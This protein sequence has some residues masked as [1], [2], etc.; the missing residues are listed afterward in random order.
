MEALRECIPDPRQRRK[1]NWSEPNLRSF[2]RE[3]ILPPLSPSIL[4]PQVTLQRLCYTELYSLSPA[5][6]GEPFLWAHPHRRRE[7]GG[8]DL[9]CGSSV[10]QSIPLPLSTLGKAW[11]AEPQGPADLGYGFRSSGQATVWGSST[12]RGLDPVSSALGGRPTLAEGSGK[13]ALPSRCGGFWRPRHSNSHEF[14][15]HPLVSPPMFSWW[16][17]GEKSAAVFA[18][19]PKGFHR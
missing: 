6:R 10:H 4:Q 17:E 7:E 18:A 5:S 13:A 8:T 19:F 11:R 15:V 1:R 14:L 9:S 12:V 2:F 16:L 3:L